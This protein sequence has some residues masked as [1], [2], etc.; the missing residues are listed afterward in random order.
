MVIF[1]IGNKVES[2][3]SGPSDEDGSDKPLD[4][5]PRALRFIPKIIKG[6]KC[7]LTSGFIRF[8]RLIKGF[9]LPL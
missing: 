9:D 4:R 7:G 1:A 6:G 3:I 2:L 5:D 8:I